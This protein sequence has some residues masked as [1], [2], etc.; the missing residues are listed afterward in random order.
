MLPS[1]A[2]PLHKTQALRLHT[3]GHWGIL[4]AE[5]YMRLCLQDKSFPQTASASPNLLLDE[6]IHAE[7]VC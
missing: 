2:R 5:T 4:S 6:A 7:A 3:D 1:H